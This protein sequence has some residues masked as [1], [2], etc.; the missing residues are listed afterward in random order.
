MKKKVFVTG[1]K[2]Y[3]GTVFCNLFKKKYNL[4]GCDIN[5]FT[6]KKDFK[7]LVKRDYDIDTGKLKTR[8]LLGVDTV[9]HLAAISNDPM[10]EEFKNLTTKV[11]LKNS[12]KLFN[13]CVKS[14]VRKFIFASSCSVYG[15]SSQNQYSCEQS[16]PRPL[17]TYS[18]TKNL[19]EKFL[20]SQKTSV[21]IYILR[22][23]T[24]AGVSKNFRLDLSLN[25]LVYSSIKTKLIN[26]LS[27]GKPIRPFIDVHD[28]SRSFDYFIEEKNFS[29]KA[30]VL[31]VGINKNNISIKNLAKLI[32]EKTK[33]PYNINK[34][35]QIDK[36][37][38]KVNFGKFK[39]RTG[40]LTKNFYDLKKIIES[41]VKY[42]K[43]SKFKEQSRNYRLNYLKKKQIEKKYSF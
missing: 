31:N 7:I 28:M 24:A 32:S 25:N 33:T 13:L 18:Q 26:V 16:K 4:Y 38:Y 22:F 3:V 2:G 43:S 42:F 27:N 8:H 10:G 9:V 21:K 14:N 12:I 29:P 1:F 37:S 15:A 39:K 19:F 11:N 5:F 41:L 40:T 30:E 6:R 36:R 34:N 35:A 20:L 17:T 23:A